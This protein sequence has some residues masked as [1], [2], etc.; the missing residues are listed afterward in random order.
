MRLSGRFRMRWEPPAR[1]HGERMARVGLVSLYVVE[2]NGIR[3]L[4]AALRNAGIETDEYYLG[5]HLHHVPRKNDPAEIDRLV[6]LMRA[7]NVGLVGISARIGALMPLA[8]E[9]TAILR[10][11]L[12]VPIV[13]GGAH[14]TMA[15]EECIDHADFLVLGEGEAALTDLATRFFAG[16]PTHDV[17]NT[18]LRTDGEVRRNPLRNL[19]EDL[20]DLPFP[21]FHS[22]REKFWIKDGEVVEGDPLAED[23]S[24]RVMV[25]RGC[26]NNCGFCGV[27][28][29]R[30]VYEGRGR[31]YRMRSVEN[32]IRELEHART[33]RPRIRRVRFDDELFVPK[34][35]WLEEFC[36]E[37]KA[38]VNLPFDILSSPRI[39]DE[40][41]V[42]RLADAGLDMVYLGVQTTSSANRQRYHRTVPDDEVQGCV[43]RLHARNVRPM[44]QIL[45]DDP[46][47]THE[48]KQELLRLL[49][50]LPRP[51]DL[52]IYSLCH[53]PGTTRTLQLL[54]EGI[55]SADDVEGRN[56]KVL[57]Q[58]NADFTHD[59]SDE[60]QAWLALYMLANKRAVPRTVV[61]QLARQKWIFSHPAPV[62]AYAQAINMGKLAVRG[63]QALIRGELSLQTVRQWLGTKK[64][65]SLPAV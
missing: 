15:P 29:F 2:S 1:R 23:R 56:D 20:D 39:L 19:V 51:Y 46:D 44:V 6:E 59:R 3:Y 24:Y 7:R 55:I 34:R 60:D 32:T 47:N 64:P 65:G 35:E 38:R 58:F 8:I 16:E 18:W 28:A 9:L 13:W 53:W 10:E 21:D 30:R 57:R 12:G 31:F 27:S 45:I 22:T 63:T 42:D 33:V 4:S 50:T 26:V 17:P 25:T 14:V 37:Y 49:L 40:W 62:V 48:E 61:R 36:R 43:R 52:L 54:A 41:T 5:Y 11:R